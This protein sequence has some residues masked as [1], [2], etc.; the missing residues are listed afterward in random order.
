[1][2]DLVCGGFMTIRLTIKSAIWRGHVVDVVN[3]VD[4]LVP[5]IKGNGYGFGRHWLAE[6]AAE[7]ADTVAVGTVHELDGL[8]DRLTP[9]VLTPASFDVL[10]LDDVRS[11]LASVDP[12]LTVGAPEHVAALDHEGWRGRVVVKLASA[13]QRFGRG[14]E[15]VDVAV[16]AGLDVV[17]VAVHPPLTGDDAD[18]VADVEAAIAAIDPA[19]AVWVSHLGID[20]Y[21]ALC[22]Q[23]PDLTFRLRLGTAL[24]HGDKRTFHLTADVLDVRQVSIGE[25]AGYRQ[26]EVAGDGHL[27][28]VGA[29]T[30]NG[31][32]LLDGGLSPF[33]FNRR[34]LTLH[35]PPHMHTSMA[36]VPAGESVPQIGARVDLQRPLI[37]TLVD[38]F[39]WI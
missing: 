36:F 38:E 27:V 18:H 19:L 25:R 11:Q 2:R 10:R 23:H 4:G 33:H 24:W 39:D 30:A 34:R 31:V 21:A 8:P 35:E 5:V 29:G 14:H 1:M 6:R 37:T 22:A 26:G 12:V 32:A 3:R 17:G 20:S 15:L 13:M 16:G 28:M 9:V 7:F